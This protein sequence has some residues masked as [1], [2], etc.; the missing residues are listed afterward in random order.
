MIYKHII[1]KNIKPFYIICDIYDINNNLNLQKLLITENDYKFININ[2]ID[3][4][5]KYLINKWIIFIQDIDLTFIN[6]HNITSIIDIFI[7]IN[8][9]IP[10]YKLINVIKLQIYDNNEIITF[11]NN[12]I[13][14]KYKYCNKFNFKINFPKNTIQL[15][16]QLLTSKIDLQKL[17]KIKNINKYN[18]DNNLYYKINQLI[19]KFILDYNDIHYNCNIIKY[20]QYYIIRYYLILLIIIILCFLIFI[21]K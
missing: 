21:F 11:N 16:Q 19:N 20:K 5:I 17:D 7:Q 6:E 15:N 18:I 3:N 2:N 4:Y 10:L 12:Y 1:N 9:Y 14:Y 13:E 8:K